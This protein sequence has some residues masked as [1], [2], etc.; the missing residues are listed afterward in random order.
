MIS[1]RNAL[2]SV[3]A[4]AAAANALTVASPASM[5]QCQPV[6]LSWADGVAP[7]YV[8][9]IPGNEPAGAALAQLDTQQGMSVTWM[10]TLAAGQ[11]VTIK[12]TDSSGAV[13]YSSAIPIQTGSSTDCTASTG[14]STGAAAPAA[15]AND[16]D[17]TDASASGSSSSSSSSA[18][19]AMTRS[20]SARASATSSAAALSFSPSS[21]A[22]SAA[23]S[24]SSG[25]AAAAAAASSPA[26]TGAA[27]VGAKAGMG[28]LAGGLLLALAA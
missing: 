21:S 5:V 4:L 22:R 23:N 18:T 16:D 10:V 17:D 27:S 3:A 12:V 26:A 6:Q 28:M 7:F 1:T 24:A 13:Q 9:I 20:T 15:A 14:S 11:D 8:A 2:F 19:L 25:I